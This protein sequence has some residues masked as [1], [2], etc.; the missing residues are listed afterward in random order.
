M[1]DCSLRGS[2]QGL[3]RTRDSWECS[4]PLGS[5]QAKPRLLVEQVS[6]APAALGMRWEV[7]HGGGFRSSAVASLVA[8]G[9][10][11]AL[12]RIVSLV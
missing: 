11:P 2:V 5:T 4:Y 10:S 12:S 9:W 1:A 7:P 6:C 8:R 3:A